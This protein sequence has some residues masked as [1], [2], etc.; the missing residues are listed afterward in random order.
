[1]KPAAYCEGMDDRFQVN[2]DPR[3]GKTLTR[4]VEEGIRSLIATGRYAPGD[5]LPPRGAIA[6]RLKARRSRMR[7][8][9]VRT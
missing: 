8:D 1:M 2:I 9:S 6:K 4:Q 3:S 7:T 5:T